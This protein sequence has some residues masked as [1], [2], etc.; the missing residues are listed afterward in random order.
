MKEM[1]QS[2]MWVTQAQAVNGSLETGIT[3][4]GATQAT[5]YQLTKVIS[6]VTTTAASTGVLLPAGLAAGDHTIVRNGGANALTVYPQGAG[7]INGA[8][9]LSIAAGKVAYL[10]NIDG[11]N[12]IAL[13][14]A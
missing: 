5:A 8:A 4:A 14:G 10:I 9:T 1:Q 2:G 13:S 3:A 12:W 7:T 6:N 11:I